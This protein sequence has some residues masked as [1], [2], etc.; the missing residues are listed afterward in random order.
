MAD[1]NKPVSDEASVALAADHAAVLKHMDM[2]QNIITRMANNSAACKK[3][4]IPLITL[5]LGFVVKENQPLLV[6]VTIIPVMIFY[7]VDCYYL[8]L[9]RQF[10]AGFNSSADKIREGTFTTADLFN[11]APGG[12]PEE[13]W[14]V[15]LNSKSTWP[16]Y[17]GLFIAVILS[18]M[19]V[20]PNVS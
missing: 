11:L 6:W 15:S 19:L 18:A 20:V 16:I 4:G 13:E 5:I 9:E 14:K 7:L 12:D 2:Y 1:A 10:R 3:W 8:G 17:L